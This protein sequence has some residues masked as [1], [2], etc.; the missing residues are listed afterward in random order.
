MRDDA[1]VAFFHYRCVVKREGL[2]LRWEIK[3]GFSRI[4]SILGDRVECLHLEETALFVQW[5]N[6]GHCVVEL[7]DLGLSTRC[8]TEV[9]LLE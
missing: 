8:M 1:L 7:V 5:W 9:C 4:E 2:P 3:A 6:R